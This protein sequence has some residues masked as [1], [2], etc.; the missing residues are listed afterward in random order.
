M[1]MKH[2]LFLTDR[3]FPSRSCFQ[4]SQ[5]ELHSESGKRTPRNDR[6]IVRCYKLKI[7]VVSVKYN[8][9]ASLS[10]NTLNL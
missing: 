7:S 8:G 4:S 1:T 9:K 5:K 6:L 3:N 2:N 10:Y